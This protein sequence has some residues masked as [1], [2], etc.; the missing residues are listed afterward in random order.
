MTQLSLWKSGSI[1]AL[2]WRRCQSFFVDSGSVT[3]RHCSDTTNARHFDGKQ[4]D[5]AF[6]ARR[7]RALVLS[8]WLPKNR[9][10]KACGHRCWRGRTRRVLACA[11]HGGSVD[12]HTSWGGGQLRHPDFPIHLAKSSKS[13]IFHGFSMQIYQ[14]QWEIVDFVD[15]PRCLGK[16]GCRS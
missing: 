5:W 15:F 14:F 6:C 16:S 12:L 1:L 10:D 2:Q 8:S 7:G 9:R 3:C 11:P 4:N 13:M